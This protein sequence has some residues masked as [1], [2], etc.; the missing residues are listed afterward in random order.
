MNE[1]TPPAVE[2]RDIAKQFPG[3]KALDGVSLAVRAGEVHA[4]MGEN[5]AGKSTL[6]KILSGAY[7]AD[8]GEIRMGGAPVLLHG[9]PDAHRHGIRM[10]YQELT[11]LANLDVGRNILLGREPMRGPFIDWPA[12]YRRAQEILDGLNLRIDARTPLERLPI[13]EQQ[14]VEI[15]R[16]VVE[17]PRVIVMDEPTSSL[18][19]SEEEAL[20]D[21]VRL[22][23][24]RGVAVI[25][26]S[27]RMEEVF[28]LS[29]RVTVLRDGRW[30]GTR[31]I[32]EVDQRQLIEMMVGRAVEQLQHTRTGR[33][34]EVLLEARHLASG[35]RVRDVSFRLHK[36]EVLGFAGLVGAGRT[37]TALALFGAERLDGGEI[38]LDG[39]P[40]RPAGPA[41][42]I[43]RG[44][45]Y[46]PEDRKQLGLILMMSVRQNM[47]LPSLRR[48]SRFGLVQRRAVGGLVDRYVQRL[49]VRTPSPDQVVELLSGGNQ[50]KVV[51]AKWLAVGPKVLILDEPTRG[52]DIGAKVEVHRLIREIA[53]TGVAVILISSELPEVLRES[54][55]IAVFHQGR[56]AGELTDREAT[57]ESV[58]SLAFGQG[59]ASRPKTEAVH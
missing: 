5:G 19:R 20:F 11:V 35:P 54:D 13:G 2:L 47:A 4:L 37:E 10:I 39:A 8:A 26:I 32:G 58:L 7:H 29:D 36:G 14:M 28:L 48:H 34:D 22:L 59:D 30:I 53:A 55:R 1:P 17:D 33:H 12:L 18:S 16:A 27:H 45:L 21:L 41:D 3:V 42:A 44:I 38:L 9:P 49:N 50:Q 24:R 57:E 40:I 25:Y 15:A 51:L 56:I 6:M 43:D 23:R 52:I 46:V 31:E